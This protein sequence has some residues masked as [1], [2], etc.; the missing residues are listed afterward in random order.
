MKEQEK[1]KAAEVAKG[2]QRHACEVRKQVKEKEDEKIASRRA[3]FEEGMKLDLEA[4][5]R[6][7]TSSSGTEKERERE[8]EREEH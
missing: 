5:E 2:I 8:R 4:K 3:F 1:L 7:V 6:S